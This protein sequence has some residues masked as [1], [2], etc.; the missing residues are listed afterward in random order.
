MSLS[1]K[2]RD[3]TWREVDALRQRLVS[4]WAARIQTQFRQELK[5]LQRDIS[6][7]SLR[8]IE[9]EWDKL[10]SGL[11]RDV[12]ATI[13]QDTV[14]RLDAAR[15]ARVVNK[16]SF[17]VA[18]SAEEIPRGWRADP[19]EAAYSRGGTARTAEKV[20]GICDTTRGKIK[21][22]IQTTYRDE[23]PDAAAAAI[24]SAYVGFTSRRA[25]TIART[26]G[27]AAANFANHAVAET[28][29]YPPNKKVWISSRD[30]RV[31]DSH[32]HLDGQSVKL[33]GL[34]SNGL[35]YPCDPAG[36]AKEVINCRCVAS[37]EY[38]LPDDLPD[39]PEPAAEE[40]APVQGPKTKTQMEFDD[41]WGVD[42]T[43]GLR[44]SAKDITH[45]NVTNAGAVLRK[46][47][48]PKVINLSKLIQ[49]KE[50]SIQKL[51]FKT[52]IMELEL[53]EHL[54][55]IKDNLY[56][57]EQIAE[58][59]ALDGE[60]YHKVKELKKLREEVADH[61]AQKSQAI[62]DAIESVNPGGITFGQPAERWASGSDSKLLKD[63]DI[64]LA[65]IPSRIAAG[66]R[67]HPGAPPKITL[68]LDPDRARYN[69]GDIY[70][71]EGDPRTL[72]HEY[73]HGAEDADKQL[74]RLSNDYRKHRGGNEAPVK[75]SEAT[76]IV[77]YGDHEETQVDR[78]FNP[79]VGKIYL[80][81]G[82]EILSMGVEYLMFDNLF[83]EDEYLADYVMGILAGYATP[84]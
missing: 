23:G 29:S 67:A 45:E 56:T 75:M 55:A 3:K 59:D 6:M 68:H 7:G 27:A 5:R 33:D 21:H 4:K 76:G 61:K 37:Y 47:I 66:E 28:S 69:G 51:T 11:W 39:A 20:K 42:E 2:Q 32:R 40:A 82:T 74:S 65:D 80:L 19:W 72:L 62:R 30:D 34:F 31:R 25:W 38:D 52:K 8:G 10:L 43:T 48:A 79:Y 46:Q 18:D 36:P 63:A 81:G 54:Q 17:G 24:K 12:M 70:T 9:G 22:I 50:V 13:G 58:V 49:R 35:K 83:E 41:A 64:A 53:E 15:S 73:M 1:V 84:K 78:W 60:R 14:R 26:E 44:K 57:D 71:A 77:E 16:K